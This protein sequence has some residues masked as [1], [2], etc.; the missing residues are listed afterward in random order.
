MSEAHPDTYSKTLFGFWLYLLS[1]FILFG[2]LFAAY[3][4]LKDST[5]GGPSGHELFDLPSTFA[6]TLILIT[7][8]LTSGMGGVF[9]HRKNKKGT[10]VMFGVTAL[11]G[12]VFL[13]L[14]MR[15]FSTLIDAGHTWKGSAFLSTF[16][17]LVGTHGAHVLIAILWTLILLPT[18]YWRG[19]DSV[20]LQRMA[21]LK[22][23]WQYINVVWIFIFTLVYLLGGKLA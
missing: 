18:V 4:V 12:F 11:L 19:I 22:L 1:D 15:E 20:V 10:V 5:F 9:A 7:V 21:C 2:A 3:A 23:F 17:S 13:G 14:M 8:S 16:F 6:Q